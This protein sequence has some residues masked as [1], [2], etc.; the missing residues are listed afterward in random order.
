M[1]EHEC[2]RSTNIS[3][4]IRQGGGYSRSEFNRMTVILQRLFS[5]YQTLDPKDVFLFQDSQQC[6]QTGQQQNICK[7]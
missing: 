2:L 6:Q 7:S 5:L 4:E 3:P 1:T